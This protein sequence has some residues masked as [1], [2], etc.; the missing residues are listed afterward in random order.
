MMF[1][2]NIELLRQDHICKIRRIF[3]TILFLLTNI[4]G[5]VFKSGDSVSPS[6]ATILVAFCGIV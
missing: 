6:M 4:Q 2:A 5:E 1:A 3:M